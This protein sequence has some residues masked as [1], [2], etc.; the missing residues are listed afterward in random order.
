MEKNTN[1]KTIIG[2]GVTILLPLI[3][4]VIPVQ[5]MFTEDLRKFFMITVFVILIIAFELIPKL[6]A[7]ILLPTLYLVTGL[8]PVEVAFGSWTN[9]TVWMVL[10]GLVFSAVLEECGLLER[11]AYFIITKCGGTYVGTVFACF[12]IGIILNLITFCPDRKSASVKGL[13][14][15]K[16]KENTFQNPSFTPIFMTGTCTGLP[17]GC[18]KAEV[19]SS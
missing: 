12:V 17:T 14:S 16:R 8:A 15:R 6:A 4:G 11:I 13:P 5:G 18:T 7:S 10:G 3:I 19:A 1:R 9:T 2:W